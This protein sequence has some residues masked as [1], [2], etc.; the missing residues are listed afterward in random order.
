MCTAVQEVLVISRLMAR[1]LA[2]SRRTLLEEDEASKLR[3]SRACIVHIVIRRVAA[4]SMPKL[5]GHIVSRG[6][7]KR[8]LAVRSGFLFQR[9]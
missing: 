9:G 5:S 7:F 6:T 8:S 4:G 1:W 3:E 2:T